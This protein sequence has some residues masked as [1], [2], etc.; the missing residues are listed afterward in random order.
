[1]SS[2]PVTSIEELSIQSAKL[3]RE[4]VLPCAAIC[5]K[6]SPTST[7]PTRPRLTPPSIHAFLSTCARRSGSS[8][9][10]EMSAHW[11]GAA[12]IVVTLVLRPEGEA[13]SRRAALQRRHRPERE[14][15]EAHARRQGLH[16]ERH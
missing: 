16:R 8:A 4:E 9:E 13:R 11:V 7:E 3:C 5:T 14:H 1:M 15:Q 6:S 10:S 12:S 2:T